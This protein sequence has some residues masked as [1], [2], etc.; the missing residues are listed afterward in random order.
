MGEHAE[1]IHAEY[2]RRLRKL[3]DILGYDTRM[4]KTGLYHLANPDAIWYV[5]TKIGSDQIPG[6]VPLVVFEVL[7]SENEK[8]IRGSISSLGLYGS[9]I[10]ILVMITEKYRTLKKGKTSEDWADYVTNLIKALGLERRIFLWYETDVDSL[11]KRAEA[12][13][14]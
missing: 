7:S 8:M 5:D 13:S 9:P 14:N 4:S 2:C 12:K 6:K 11:L 3:G 10:G 1:N